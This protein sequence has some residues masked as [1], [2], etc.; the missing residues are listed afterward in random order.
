[1]VENPRS[2]CALLEGAYG[3]EDLSALMSTTW[4]IT[5]PQNSPNDNQ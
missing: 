3:G 4:D 5:Q 1:M 2:N